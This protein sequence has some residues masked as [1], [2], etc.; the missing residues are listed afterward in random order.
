MIAGSLN[1]QVGLEPRR[2]QH[3][4]VSFRNQGLHLRRQSEVN[5]GL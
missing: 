3:K 1:I 5:R 4:K 2:K